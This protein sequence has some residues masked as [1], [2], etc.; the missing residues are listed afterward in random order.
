M[1]GFWKLANI[2]LDSE[3]MEAFFT[4]DYLPLNNSLLL[5]VC[6][7]DTR[8]SVSGTIRSRRLM[9]LVLFFLPV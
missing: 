6:D 5:G 2:T 8:N 7:F 1:V 4:G 3:T 9:E